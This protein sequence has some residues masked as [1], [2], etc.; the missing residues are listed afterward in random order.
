MEDNRKGIEENTLVVMQSGDRMKQ[1]LEAIGVRGN[2]RLNNMM[3]GGLQ[4]MTKEIQRTEK[5]EKK[6]T[7]EG[8]T[9]E[10]KKIER[11]LN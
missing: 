2:G 9:V 4:A 7:L 1:K 8:S 3:V 5:E 6:K 10:E 11:M